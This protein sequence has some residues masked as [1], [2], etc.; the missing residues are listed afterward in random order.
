[1]PER[2]DTGSV[3]ECGWPTFHS[4]LECAVIGSSAAR[5]SL[6]TW[7]HSLS[8]CRQMQQA[9]SSVSQ[10]KKRRT[11]GKGCN[12]IPWTV[13]LNYPLLSSNVEH[14][15][16]ALEWQGDMRFPHYERSNFRFHSRTLV[17]RVPC[18]CI[19][20]VSVTDILIVV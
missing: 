13:H 11:I 16:R 12:P 7:T 8:T 19:G 15:S 9:I 1:M 14:G 3:R 6:H 20:T 5:S 2:Y 4:W 17:G 18:L 10:V